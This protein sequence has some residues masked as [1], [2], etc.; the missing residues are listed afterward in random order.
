MKHRVTG[1]IV[2]RYLPAGYS[3]VY[4]C[5]MPPG[6]AIRSN[7]FEGKRGDRRTGGGSGRNGKNNR[8]T[9]FIER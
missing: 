9:E 8:P 3:D 1:N 2:G 6:K 4:I 5:E 7:N